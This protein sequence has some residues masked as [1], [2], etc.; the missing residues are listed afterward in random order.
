MLLVN[1]ICVLGFFI[2]IYM[3]F[4]ILEEVRLDFKSLGM[5]RLYS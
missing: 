2:F 1:Y 5:K 4:I 3:G